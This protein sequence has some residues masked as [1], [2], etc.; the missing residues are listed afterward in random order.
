MLST[1]IRPPLKKKKKHIGAISSKLCVTNVSKSVCMLDL[2]IL[3]KLPEM[4]NNRVSQK[5]SYL[6]CVSLSLC[7]LCKYRQCCIDTKTQ[8]AL[9]QL[10][11]KS[12][13]Q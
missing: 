4:H 13:Q 11:S 3:P 9:L 6:L 5:K 10:I 7:S 2:N 12:A 8:L 1:K